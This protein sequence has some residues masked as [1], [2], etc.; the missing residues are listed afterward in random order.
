MG[1]SEEHFR[2]VLFPIL[3]ELRDYLPQI[4]LIGGWVP[5]LHR[6]FG[7]AGGWEKD[8]VSTVELD[9]LLSETPAQGSPGALSEVLLGAGFQAVDRNSPPAVWE[10]DTAR[11]ERIEFFLGHSGPAKTVGGVGPVPGE[12]G[13]GALSLEGMQ[14][15]RE[16]IVE[17]PVNAEGKRSGTDTLS[18][19]VP[20]LPAFL[21]HKGAIFFRRSE[22]EKRAKDLLYIVELMREGGP[23]VEGVEEG[24][25]ALCRDPGG[26]PSVARTA[27]NNISL[28]LAQTDGDLIPLLSD[29]LAVRT[30]WSAPLAR[31]RARGFLQDFVDLIPEDCGG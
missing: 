17:L 18:V 22:R 2:L 12:V 1:T 29:A 9:V 15:L 8:P 4:V 27:R 14:F 21:I 6:H 23:L 10:R 30:G 3:S 13:V 11:G 26:G 20:S 31:S 24:I 5:F 25:H 19:R 7:G 16:Q 28:A